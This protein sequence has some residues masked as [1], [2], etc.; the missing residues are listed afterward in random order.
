MVPSSYALHPNHPNPF[1]PSTSIRLD[2]PD[3]GT[4][5]LAVYDVLGRR[6]RSLL[7]SEVC[8]GSHVVTWDGRDDGGLDVAS[9]LYLRRIVTGDFTAIGRMLLLK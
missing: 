9:G 3:G 8:M 1:N 2:L 7:S 6:V 5:E 4:V